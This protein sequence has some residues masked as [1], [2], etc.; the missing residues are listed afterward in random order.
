MID[1]RQYFSCWQRMLIVKRIMSLA[2]ETFNLDDFYANDV[3]VDPVR[4]GKKN[5]APAWGR[6]PEKPQVIMCPPLP[7]PVL[8][9]DW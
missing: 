4:D 9:E 6:I 8:K 1:N 7:P 5:A 3:A 2:G